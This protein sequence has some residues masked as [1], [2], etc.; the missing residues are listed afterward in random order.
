M[1]EANKQKVSVQLS[2]VSGQMDVGDEEFSRSK[3]MGE[4]TQVG[5]GD[6]QG[7]S[8]V[9]TTGTIWINQSGRVGIAH[10]Y[11]I[12]TVMGVNVTYIMMLILT[13][14]DFNGGQCPPYK[15]DG[16]KICQITGGRGYRVRHISLRSSPTNGKGY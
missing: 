5:T 2:A 16:N 11:L 9:S 7:K 3:G 6:L 4:G 1:A 10:H 8:R 15:M 14:V 13:E 12:H